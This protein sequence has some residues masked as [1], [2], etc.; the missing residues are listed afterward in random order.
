MVAAAAAAVVAAAAAVAVGD[1][2]EKPTCLNYWEEATNNDDDDD[3][4]G[5]VQNERPSAHVRQRNRQS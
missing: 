3:N 2:L 1:W 4:N 5:D